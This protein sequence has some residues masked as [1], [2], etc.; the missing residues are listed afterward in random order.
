MVGPFLHAGGEGPMAV[1]TFASEVE[2]R[3][4]ARGASQSLVEVLR[5]L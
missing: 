3:G 1:I 2:L 4:K 5:V